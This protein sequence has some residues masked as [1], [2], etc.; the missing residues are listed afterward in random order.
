MWLGASDIATEGS[1][2]WVD[3]STLDN[4]SN[5]GNGIYGSE[6][7]NSMGAQDALAMGMTPWPY[8]EGGLGSAGQWND[9]NQDNT[10]YYLVEWQQITLTQVQGSAELDQKTY[11]G[12]FS[13]YNLSKLVDGHQVLSTA[14]AAPISDELLSIERLFFDDKNI[15][16]DL[17]GSA[18]FVAKTLGAVFGK[19]SVNNLNYVATGLH[20]LDN[21]SSETALMGLALNVALANNKNNGTVVDL[22]F[23]NLLA[24]APS[25][26]EKNYY[27]SLLENN[28]HTQESLS[29]FAA[30]TVL[31]SNN[32]N[33]TGLQQ[34]GLAYLL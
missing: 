24:K 27:V 15:A 25:V 2:Q 14:G 12:N 18:G 32:I 4:Y 9:I 11:S 6:P 30:E 1:W 23:N 20:L 33:L 16:L 26:A 31:N 22:L 29:I 34:E 28:T 7:D 3:N 5:W 13:D 10:L 17:D 8:P 19:E 21:G